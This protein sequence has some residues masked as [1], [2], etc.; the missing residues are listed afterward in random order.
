[1]NKK[2]FKTARWIGL[3]IV[4]ISG[5]ISIIATGG[6]GDGNGGGGGSGYNLEID[7][8]LMS[9]Y[10]VG[11]STLSLDGNIIG[12]DT[13]P[14]NSAWSGITV[15]VKGVK[16]GWHTLTITIVRQNRYEQ[17]YGANGSIFDEDSGEAILLKTKA[18]TLRAGESIVYQFNTSD[19][20]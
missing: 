11:E 5:L 1:M 10:G 3:L 4:I 17:H 13:N 2:L 19:L 16:S 15:N 9:E 7:I 8:S 12:R 18:A 6:G 20:Q 14:N